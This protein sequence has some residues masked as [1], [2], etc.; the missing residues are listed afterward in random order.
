MSYKIRKDTRIR[1]IELGID[2]K[3]TD[4]IGIGI[5]LP[6][7]GIDPLELELALKTLI[8]SWSATGQHAAG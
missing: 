6:R 1:R 7:I 5:D 3:N 2:P 8:L 4:R